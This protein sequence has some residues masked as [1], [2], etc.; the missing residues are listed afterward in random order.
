MLRHQ[1]KK[2][3]LP[4]LALFT[5]LLTFSGLAFAGGGGGGGVLGAILGVVAVIA[6]PFTFGSSLVLAGALLGGAAVGYMLGTTIEMMIHPPSFDM[7]NMS[8]SAAATQN[9]GTTVNKQGTNNSIPV[10]YGQRRIGG[11]RVFV[12]TNG[13]ENRDLYMA[14]VLCEGEI[15]SIVRVMIDDVT[16]WTGSTVHAT[17]YTA[18]QS[19]FQSYF[20]FAAYHG[21]AGQA[22]SILL[23]NAS[24]WDDTKKLS[25]LAYV[26]VKCSWPNIANNDDAKKNPWGGIPNIVFELRG[27]RVAMP[28]NFSSDYT[29]ITY[30]ARQNWNKNTYLATVAYSNNPVDCLLDYL[31]NTIYGK[32]LADTQIDWHSFYRER[33]R[34]TKDQNGNTLATNLTHTTNAVIFTDRTVMENVKTILL[35][36]RSSLIYQDGRYRLVVVDNGSQ[37]SIY[38]A[39]S[40]SVMTVTTED[41]IDG[42]KIQTETADAKANRIIVSY[43]GYIGSEAGTDIKTYE[44]IDYVYPPVGSGLETQY[45]S[46][47]G[48]RS[49]ETKVT[50]EHVTDAT[51]A[52]KLAQIILERGRSKGKIVTFQ[53]TSRLYQLEV[54]DIVTLQYPSL[55]ITGQYRVKGSVQNE[56]F[57]FVITLEEH[58]DVTYAYNPT[59]QVNT[60]Y[61]QWKMADPNKVPGAGPILPGPPVAPAA[62]VVVRFFSNKGGYSAPSYNIDPY[63]ERRSNGSGICVMG[64]AIAVP[65]SQLV[66]IT[67]CSIYTRL[68]GAPEWYLTGSTIFNNSAASGYSGLWSPSTAAQAGFPEG[69]T[70][71]VRYDFKDISMPIN[72]QSVAFSITDQYTMPTATAPGI[73]Y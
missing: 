52:A 58:T 17:E 3:N 39:A 68:V 67:S 38:A 60:K 61:R 4:T 51:T 50:L 32:G 13:T 19:A 35:N 23:K 14:L 31:Q 57:T 36:M 28:T 73:N 5:V 43:M 29:N 24:G 47:D 40:T 25:G 11:S 44:S 15:D 33:V 56:D 72:G 54:G 71:E 65:N 55:S 66:N 64:T 34:W 49:V 26:A 42:I 20:T 2:F 10:V 12:G 27:K 7:P 21:T 30:A 59:P 6:A 16:V 22:A 45:L 46:E 41:I 53:G 9:A 70:I 8:N 18:N 1:L 37:T 63:F 69:I 48:G 62:P